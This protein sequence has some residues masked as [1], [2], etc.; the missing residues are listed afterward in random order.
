MGNVNTVNILGLWNIIL[1]V[2]LSVVIL[3]AVNN[4]N[5]YTNI[6][7]IVGLYNIIVILLIMKVGMYR[8]GTY[9]GAAR[10]SL[11][12]KILM[13]MKRNNRFFLRMGFYI[14]TGVLI[15]FKMSRYSSSPGFEYK[16]VFNLLK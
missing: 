2:L 10:L 16:T 9:Y 15:L 12:D 4:K 8:V 7:A 11:W 14:I 3:F 6:L 1:S 5:R 13:K